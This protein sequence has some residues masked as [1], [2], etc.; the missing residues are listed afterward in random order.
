MATSFHDL[1]DDQR[2]IPFVYDY[3]DTRCATCRLTRRCLLFVARER[4]VPQDDDWVDEM[5]ALLRAMVERTEGGKKAIARLDVALCDSA[6]P[7]S[8]RAIGH[9]LHVLAR[10]YTVS[11]ARFLASLQPLR[12]GRPA[13]G[14]PLDVV[15]WDHDLIDFKTYRTLVSHFTGER[16]PGLEPDTLAC[17]KSV[18]V[19]V[20][21]SIEA[22]RSLARGQDEARV[23]GLVEMLEALRT[24]MEMRFP[25]A[26]AFVRPGLDEAAGSP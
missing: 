17:A 4:T 2:L 12:G 1:L 22:W 23:A 7:S 25:G 6:L 3:C 26:R 20:D 9:P 13:P 8:E 16:T 14:S 21:R 11:A 10:H 15:A 19:F 24:G 5:V 18:L